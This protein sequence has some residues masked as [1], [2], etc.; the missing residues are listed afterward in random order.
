MRYIALALLAALRFSQA[1]Q[2]GFSIHDDLLA[3]PQFEL[4]FSDDFISETDALA[5]LESSGPQSPAYRAESSSQTDLTSNVRESAAANAPPVPGSSSSGDNLPDDDDTPISETYE[6]INSAPWRYLCAVPVIAPPPVLNRTAT[7]LAKAEEARELSRASAKGWELMSGLDGHCMYF[8]SGWWSYSFC[9]GKSV[10]Q[11]HAIPSNKGG[12]P[13]KDENSQEYVLGRIDGL[14]GAQD[15]ASPEGQTKSLTPPNAQLQ[16]KGD[17]RY[18]S[19]RLEHGTICDLT[20]RP[21]TI[22]VQYH[23][24][25]GSAIDRIG[26]VKEV[27]TCTYLM[28]VYTPRLCADVA[29][30]PPKETRAHPIRCRQI[31]GTAEEESAWRYHKRVEAGDKLFSSQKKPT[32]A[33]SSNTNHNNN[34]DNKNEFTGINIGGVVVGGKKVISDA[35]AHKL[36]LPRGLSRSGGTPALVLASRKKDSAKVET[37]SDEELEKLNLDPQ[38]V[39]QFREQMQARAGNRGWKLQVELVAGQGYEYVGAF[40]E[41]EDDDQTGGG[42]GRANDAGGEEG[43]AAEGG[44]AGGEEEIAREEGEEPEGSEEV[45]FKEEL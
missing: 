26:W 4:V 44:K 31:I 24:S 45:F 30:Q 41:E 42:Q 23:C 37:M 3:Y 40:D 6:L 7:E 19:Q 21:R 27:T 9:Y 11:F 2:P 39:E 22:E 33:T 10:V 1:R 20:G 29:F 15:P 32:T 12:P 17:Q 8:M 34:N 13:V 14:H 28:V 18:L 38:T 36:P 25:P 35:L 43:E 16:V 5:L